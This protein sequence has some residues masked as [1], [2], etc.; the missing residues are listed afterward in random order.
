MMLLTGPVVTP[1]A[2]PSQRCMWYGALV[3]APTTSTIAIPPTQGNVLINDLLAK[4]N[5]CFP[6]LDNLP[7]LLDMKLVLVGISVYLDLN[8]PEGSSHYGL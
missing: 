5:T 8:M 6:T 1:P 7:R 4:P 3:N 2:I